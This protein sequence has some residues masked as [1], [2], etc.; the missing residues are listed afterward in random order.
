MM[1]SF[2]LAALFTGPLYVVGSQT[3]MDT[4]SHLRFQRSGLFRW[5]PLEPFSRGAK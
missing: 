2:I 3:F 5:L 4:E 1:T